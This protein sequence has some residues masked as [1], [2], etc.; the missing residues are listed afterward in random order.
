MKKNNST[1]RALLVLGMHRAGTSALARVLSLRGAS[2]PEHVLP[3]N[4]GNETGY[5]EPG[6]VVELNDRMLDY[7]GVEWDD[8]FAAHQ[9]PQ[10][11]AFPSRF[12][13]Q[14]RA[15]L[16]QEYP[17]SDLFVLKDPRCTL[18]RGFWTEAL[19]ALDITACPVVV[20]RPFEEVADSL[21]RRDGTSAVSA[22]LLYV[23]YGLEAAAAAGQGASVVTYEQLLADWSVT[24]NRIA[25]EQKFAWPRAGVR[26][27]AEIEAFLRATPQPP[28]RALHLPNVLMEWA[29]TVWQ[30]FEDAAHGRPRPVS[31][32]DGIR[33]EL[34]KAMGV[35]APLLV[36][37]VRRLRDLSQAS[38]QAAL[39]ARQV[40]EQFDESQS[41]LQRTVAERD[42]AL[43][44]RDTAL[45][46]HEATEN[47]LRQTEASYRQLEQ[48][49][50]GLRQTLAQRD[51]QL[52]QLQSDQAALA[53]QRDVLESERDQLLAVY[54]ATNTELGAT[55]GAYRTLEQASDDLR[56]TLAERDTALGQLQ[57]TLAQGEREHADLATRLGEV[58]NVLRQTAAERDAALAE[59]DQL[60]A[61][62]A[63]TNTELGA[64]QGAYRTLEQ[65]SDDLR[66]TLAERDTA[67]GQLQDALT[68]GE[69]QRMEAGAS[70]SAVMRRATQSQA[71]LGEVENVLRQTAAERDAAL[72][73]RDQLSAVYA[74]TNTELGAT[75]GAY[76]TLE[77]ASDDLRRTLAERDTALGQLQETLAQGE[78]EHADL[79][80]RLGEV[81]NVLH[82]T[83]AERD[84]ALSERDAALHQ[85]QQTED[86][87]HQTEASYQQLE[88]ELFELKKLESNLSTSLELARSGLSGARE[89][90]GEAQATLQRLGNERDVIQKE[91]DLIH[92]SRSW[93]ATAPLRNVARLGRSL[94]TRPSEMLRLAAPETGRERTGTAASGPAA[95]AQVPAESST[96]AAPACERRPHVELRGF[97][98]EEFGGQ[99]ADDVVQRIDR[100]RLPIATTEARGA[101]RTE[102]SQADAMAWVSLIAR[103]AAHRIDPAVEPEVSIVIPVY[104]QLPFTLAC[105][106]ALMAHQTRHA[107]EILVGDDASTDAT[108]AALAQPI[109]GV[110]HV[111]HGSNLGFVRNCNATARLARGRYVVLL[112]NDTQVL[113]GWLDELVDVLAQSPEIGLA[114]SKLIYPNGKLQECGGIV[115]RDG[116]AWNCGRMGDP[117]A[118][119][120]SY[121]RDTDYVSGAS[122]ALS[123]ALWE[124]L[125]GFDELFVP[126]YAEDVDLAFRVRASGLRTV[127]QPLSQ[128]LH[129]E[130]ISSGTDL[131]QGAKAHQV[132]NLRKLHARW[133]E[134]LAQHRD[135]AVQ[136]ELEKERAVT[137]RLLFIDLVTPTPN[138]DAGSLV[139]YEMMTGFRDSG[140]KVTFIPADNFAHMGA[141]TRDLQRVGIEPIYHPSYSSMPAFLSNRHDAF[142]L[143]LLVRFRVGEA[144][145]QQLRQRYPSARIIFSNCDLHYLREMREAELSADPAAIAAARDTK[146]RETDV[147]ARADVNLVH[148][149]AELE[150]L[151]KDVPGAPCVLFPLVH[152]PVGNRAPLEQRD[153]ICFFGGYR[154]P[155]NAD[156]IV[157]F[158]ENIWPRV[159]QQLPNEKLYVAGSSMTDDIKA[160]SRHPGVEVVGFVDDLEAF[161]ARRRVTIAPLRFGAGAK[162][163]VAASLANG[164]PVVSTFVG[165]EGM[166]LT[167]GVNVLIADS[168]EAFATSVVEVLANDRLWEQLSAAGLA[169][170]A[171]V[172]S[173]ASARRR[174]QSILR[175]LGLA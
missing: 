102:C 74:A 31:A 16:E 11:D 20:M 80:T 32:L 127:V 37:R 49:S 68:Q 156:G 77:Q 108:A 22:V 82:Q 36:D 45:R 14:A 3:A 41:S 135:N 17:D 165:A 167:P 171:E 15:I 147:I 86:R 134:V 67:L 28:T 91:L 73:E 166:Q 65:A 55:Q 100:F 34:A 141:S 78:R 155:P 169:Y 39:Q 75:Q 52:E 150:L 114:G 142:D 163:K 132:E 173:R 122:I 145:L 42:A 64:T 72:A 152:D 160:L 109:N 38:E 151:R 113:P 164:V 23:A 60:S 1:R 103:R 159:R 96:P 7:F 149:E 13:T 59:R 139:A 54:A 175:D 19:R 50:V 10:V 89:D 66:C 128:L 112:N 116:S 101:V 25:S 110:R 93:R 153:G 161:L 121:L 70:L 118:P 69:R 2:L 154:H 168:E 57:E 146:R 115:W 29:T 61:V 56:R 107:F 162:G 53:A 99:A 8:P 98:V 85:H 71:R 88:R 51:T 46:Q 105:L 35:F 148:S 43:A 4:R 26:M 48:D 172:T 58:E 130:G 119:E 124:E 158:V 83:A 140:F 79:A 104:N 5:W 6:P 95:G 136:P 123:R 62:Y 84:V 9:L 131:G 117:R 97:L 63:A 137:R 24:T 18:M 126:A 47:R 92:A 90:L 44:E 81:E 143:I 129:F 174:I 111:R 106:D 144:H 133:R 120:F 21:L 157:W 40:V 27:S 125:G 30:W 87:L 94:L 170:A 12:S 33:Q 76:R 138:E